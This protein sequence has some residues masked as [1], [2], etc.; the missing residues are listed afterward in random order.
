MAP[1]PAIIQAVEQLDHR[2]TVGDV[3]TQAGFNINLAQQELLALATAVGAHMQVAQTGEIV[4]LFPQNLRAIL[5]NKFLRLRL[6]E[7]GKILWQVLFYLIRISFGV[8]LLASLALITLVILVIIIVQEITS[9]DDNFI[10]TAWISHSWLDVFSPNYDR[11]H[12]DQRQIE[13]QSND[14]QEKENQLNFLESIFSFLFGDRNPNA[15]LEERRHKAIAAVIRNNQGAVVAEQ[16][17]PYLD[18]IGSGFTQE[19]RRLYAACTN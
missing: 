5:L 11:R 13:N 14:E 8:L 4:Y 7:W 2:V 12:Q 1:N 15:D 9:D 19:Y 10:P 17:T 16:V 6:Q 3:A 18:D